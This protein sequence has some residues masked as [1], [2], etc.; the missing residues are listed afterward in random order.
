MPDRRYTGLVKEAYSPIRRAWD[1][2][3][4]VIRMAMLRDD[5]PA[6]CV[7]ATGRHAK[8]WLYGLTAIP[9][10]TMVNK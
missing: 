4:K 9:D 10:S 5:P 2:T 6:I 3:K 8:L 1:Q 7:V